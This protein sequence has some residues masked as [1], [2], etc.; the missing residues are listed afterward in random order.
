VACGGEGA[1]G[2]IVGRLRVRVTGAVRA[3]IR[4]AETSPESGGL[5]L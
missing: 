4:G 5:M 3:A 2:V 1:V